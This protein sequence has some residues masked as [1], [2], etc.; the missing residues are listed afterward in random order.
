MRS[1]SS[2]IPQ[3]IPDAGKRRRRLVNRP[4]MKRAGN[5]ARV[6][7]ILLLSQAVCNHFLAGNDIASVAGLVLPATTVT[8]RTIDFDS[9]E[10]NRRLKTPS[11]ARHHLLSKTPQPPWLSREPRRR[12]E[13]LRLSD[14]K[15][16]PEEIDSSTTVISG[17]PKTLDTGSLSPSVDSD[18]V[19]KN[20]AEQRLLMNPMENFAT[21]EA[22][23]TVDVDGDG[24]DDEYK[25]GLLTIGFITLLF[26]TNS[27]VLHWA[28][29]SGNSPP[30][31]L[32]VNTAVS[33]VALVGLLLGGDTL[34]D[35][36]GSLPSSNA[37]DND[38]VG[39]STNRG[40]TGWV[41]GL[42][43]GLWKFLGTTSNLY[44]LALTTASHGALLIQLTTLI[45]PTTRALVYK[46]S[47]STK[48][49]LSIALALSG[50]VC[51]ANDPTGTP[52]LLGD[53]LCVVAAICYS[54][55]DLRLYEYG[56]I[57]DAVKPLITTKI[58]TQALFSLGLLFLAPSS[59]L[60]SEG[61]ATTTAALSPWQ[62]SSDY[63]QALFATPDWPSVVAAVLWSGV[64]VNAVAP[65]LQVCEEFKK[66][67]G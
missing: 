52:S 23:E 14:S 31:V 12:R 15:S 2:Y 35:N 7:P 38:L 26:A 11:K 50:V 66:N 25:R 51:F 48:L 22:I 28:F 33:V 46:E 16:F 45:V 20:Y 44:G 10:N 18:D 13:S 61:T 62:E 63:L 9:I 32:L 27:P 40:S 1:R 65:F 37:V 47:I 53:G 39:S 4:G 55:Y 56:K 41:G 34:E 42:E 36:N 17:T 57:V 3:L 54:A 5:I 49:Q 6:V 64:A 58:A 60:L 19:G 29:T 8:K 59:L 24:N 67:D 30:P 21:E 43:L